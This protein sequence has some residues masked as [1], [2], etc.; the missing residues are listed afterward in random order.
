MTSIGLIFKCGV[1]KPRSWN[2]SLRLQA[3]CCFKRSMSEST[4]SS[5]V[6]HVIDGIQTTSARKM[7]FILRWSFRALFQYWLSP[8]KLLI[9]SVYNMFGS[10]YNMFLFLTFCS[11][12]FESC[13][14]CKTFVQ[15]LFV[16]AIS[17]GQCFATCLALHGDFCRSRLKWDL[18]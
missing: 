2:G 10:I 9:S 3:H 12:L 11:C 17:I 18:R 16:C 13:C 7:C 8:I 15:E 1:H 4:C 6:L 5:G 14:I